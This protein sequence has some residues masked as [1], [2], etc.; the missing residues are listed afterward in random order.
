MAADPLRQSPVALRFSRPPRGKEA[1]VLILNH[2]IAGT[3]G[4]LEISKRTMRRPSAPP[5]FIA[6][7]TTASD[8]PSSTRSF[9]PKTG[10]SESTRLPIYAL[11]SAALARTSTMV[12]KIKKLTKSSKPKSLLDLESRDCRW[13]IGEPRQLDFRFCGRPQVPGHPYCE[14]H[15][16]MAF[17]PAKPRH[18]APTTMPS[19]TAKAA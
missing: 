18:Q 6:T 3:I 4:M 12:K 10:M 13:P 14:H 5:Q 7:D 17:Q 8:A 16:R 1:R 11:Y 15:R 9:S 19:A 2:A